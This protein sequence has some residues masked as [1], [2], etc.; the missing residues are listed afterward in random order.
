MSSYNTA[1]PNSAY[2]VPPP[3]RTLHPLSCQGQ[4]SLSQPRRGRSPSFL[5][6]VK[7]IVHRSRSPLRPRTSN[8]E[9]HIS[10]PLEIPQSVP[11]RRAISSPADNKAPSSRTSSRGRRERRKNIPSMIDYLTLSQLEN[12]WQRQDTYKGTVDAPQRAPQQSARFPS[13]RREEKLQVPIMD[14][15][16]ALRGSHSH[17]DLA[18]S[19]WAGVSALRHRR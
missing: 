2:L 17:D 6:S 8:G 12:V 16:P 15:H 9:I 7:D 4:E 3:Y 5:T 13:Q 18:R 1:S 11:H 14:V 19:R 10:A